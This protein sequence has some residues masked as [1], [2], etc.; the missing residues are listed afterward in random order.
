MI[1]VDKD[2]IQI[3]RFIEITSLQLT[4]YIKFTYI[5]IYNKEEVNFL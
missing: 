1:D 2:C 5:V 4:Y 3:Y